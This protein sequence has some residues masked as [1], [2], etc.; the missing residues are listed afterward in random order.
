MIGLPKDAE[1][2]DIPLDAEVL[3]DENGNEYEVHYYRYSG[4][5]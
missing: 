4:H 1:G 3:Y 5:E 2:R